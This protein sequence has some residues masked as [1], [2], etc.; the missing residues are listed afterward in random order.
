MTD[1]TAILSSLI[2]LSKEAAQLLSDAICDGCTLCV[3]QISDL[4]RQ[5][6]SELSEGE[7]LI[8]KH[9]E[10]PALLLGASAVAKTVTAV[11]SAAMLLPDRIPRLLPLEE[12]VQ[13]NAELARRL[14]ALCPPADVRAF[15]FYSFHLCANKGRGAQGLLLK[16]CCMKEA[17]KW[18]FPLAYALQSHRLSLED[19]CTALAICFSEERTRKP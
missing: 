4:N 11:F 17:G 9:G 8:L 16:N 3:S 7:R 6:L 19:A 14:S 15:P 2:A 18:I 12:M 13:S 10:D 1:S 5:A